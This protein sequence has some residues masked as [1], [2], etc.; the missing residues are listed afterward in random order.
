MIVVLGS[1]Q[2]LDLGRRIVLGQGLHGASDRAE[3]G[4]RFGAV[5]VASDGNGSGSVLVVGVPGEDVGAAR[6]AGV[7]ASFRRRD[8]ARS[9]SPA[10][11]TMRQGAR[12]VPN[13]PESGDAFGSSLAYSGGLFES[14]AVGAP[15]EDLDGVVDAGIVHAFGFANLDV[16][17]Q[18]VHQNLGIIPDIN[19]RGDRLGA[20]IGTAQA[21]CGGN[22]T[23]V[24]LIGIPGQDVG[25]ARD[26]GAVLM[27]EPDHWASFGTMLAQGF[28]HIR[29]RATAGDRFG[30]AIGR[31]GSETAIG[32]PGDD[33]GPAVDAGT[34]TLV[35]I[36]CEP[37]TDI[38]YTDRVV[39]ARTF[40][41]N[42]TGV[43]DAAQAGDRFGAM[44]GV[45]RATTS[46]GVNRTRALVV[47]APYET[48][49]DRRGAGLLHVLPVSNSFRSSVHIGSGQAFTQNSMHVADR[50]EAG[51]HFALGLP[52]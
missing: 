18:A 27:I 14:L 33:L 46:T 49:D 20:A 8:G 28:G 38:T 17:V 6:D 47:G 10:G 50:A 29:G 13:R 19:E 31:A 5:L 1:P 24:L 12:G 26:A 51:D 42:S 36:E 37:F 25:R 3:P 39:G 40:S 34:V 52:R 11:V 22:S 23:P 41:Q 7:V 32:A 21:D 9:I 2:G 44:L 48:V 30:A 16:H 43:A 45:V 35:R 15:G 4:D